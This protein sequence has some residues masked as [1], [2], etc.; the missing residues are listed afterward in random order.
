MINRIFIFGTPH[1]FE[2]GKNHPEIPLKGGGKMVCQHLELL[3]IDIKNQQFTEI[4]EDQ[5]E[6]NDD[7][8]WVYFD[9]YLDRKSIRRK[10]DF[11]DFV[12]DYIDQSPEGIPAE[13]LICEEC[14]CGI[15]GIQKGFMPGNK[16]FGYNSAG[17]P[18]VFFFE[19]SNTSEK[20]SPS[21]EKETPPEPKKKRRGFGSII[22]ALLLS[23]PIALYQYLPNHMMLG[24]V[25][26]ICSLIA[27]PLFLSPITQFI[28]G[29][30]RYS[31]PFANVFILPIL[32]IPVFILYGWQPVYY[33][34]AGYTAL[35]F[36]GS[37]I[38]RLCRRKK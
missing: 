20:S 7:V 33:I 1:F 26:G 21:N 24:L 5:H 34:L 27:V 16:V 18:H 37:I 28:R 35:L 2:K 9:C 11:P 15:I 30:E 4:P 31:F 23:I 22:F 12:E 38:V 8:H 25:A 32:G 36:F 14:G 6:T 10:W 29:K 3:V 19:N 13:G 17:E